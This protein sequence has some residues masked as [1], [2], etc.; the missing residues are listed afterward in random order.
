LLGL[1]GLLGATGCAGRPVQY[2]IEP[3]ELA[4]HLK[5]TPRAVVLD[6]RTVAAYAS[7]H[8]AGAV[9]AD[10]DEWK[11]ESL[12]EESGIEQ[13]EIWRGRI[14]ALGVDP[15][16]TVVL[17]DDGRMTE[18]ARLWFLMQHFGVERAAVVNGGWPALQPLIA[19]GT[20]KVSQEATTA[21]LRAF[22]APRTGGPVRLASR[23]ET[24]EHVARRDAQIWDARSVAEHTGAQAHRNP[25]A[26]HL[27]GAVNL[28]H[29]ELLTADG[30]LRPPHELRALLEQAG[31]DPR[32]PLVTHCESGGRA[33]L[34][35]LAALRA[36][37]GNVA[38]YY[39]SFS[40]WSADATCPIE[41]GRGESGARE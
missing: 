16:R 9:L 33:A 24:K 19:G 12:L 31:F 6:V 41:G 4:D 2:V 28:P 13:E 35:A 18:A 23:A 34:A 29:A 38:N 26:G 3:E 25:R 17:Y 20:L 36:G 37:F 22:R 15:S 21:A 8:L 11:R 27:P 7:G 39:R 5:A 14:G 1:I 32:Q 30:R 10:V 40:D